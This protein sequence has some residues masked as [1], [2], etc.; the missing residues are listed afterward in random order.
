[1]N[2]VQIKTYVARIKEHWLKYGFGHYLTFL[3][4][5]KNNPI[6]FFSLKYLSD[7]DVK[8]EISDLGF[9]LLPEYRGKG[10]AHEGAS[11][12]IKYTVNK[13][14]FKRIRA[15]NYPENKQSIKVLKKL[16]FK[17]IGKINVEYMGRNLGL[18]AQWELK[19]DG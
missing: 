11:A 6:G 8:M 3:K 12:L 2:E 14:H 13:F 9:A 19:V 5:S 16:G 1:M 15:L 10:F 17:E 4:E 18:S 7:S